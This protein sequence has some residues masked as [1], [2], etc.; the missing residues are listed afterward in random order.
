MSN[1][2]GIYSLVCRILRIDSISPERTLAYPQRACWL[3]HPRK[4]LYSSV[5]TEPGHH[6][7]ALK[8]RKLSFWFSFSSLHNASSLEIQL[9][10]LSKCQ[11]TYNLLFCPFFSFTWESLEVEWRKGTKIWAFIHVASPVYIRCYEDQCLFLTMALKSGGSLWNKCNADLN[12]LVNGV[13]ST[14]KINF[15]TEKKLKMSK[16]RTLNKIFSGYKVQLKI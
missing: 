10:W 1:V 6:R 11:L 5:V 15:L 7:D 4:C 16:A 12:I 3:I 14:I 2:I 13:E 8:W 9:R